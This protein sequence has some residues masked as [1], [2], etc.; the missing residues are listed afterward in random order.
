MRA[1][2]DD[3]GTRLKVAVTGTPGTPLVFLGN[4]EIEDRWAMG[5]PGLPGVSFPAGRA[6]VNRMDEFTLLLAGP[7][8]HVVL[9]A[10]P[11]PGYLSYLG[12]LGLTPPRILAIGR[13]DPQRTVTADILA[14]PAI[15]TALGRLARGGARL[16][17]HG[18][19]DLEEQLAETSEIPLAAPAAAVCKRVNSK[20]YSRRL[21]EELDLRR[22]RGWAAETL[23][24]LDE[25]VGRARLLLAAGHTVVVKDAYGVSGRGI[26][27]VAT[28][29]RLDRLQRM[30]IR[31]AERAGHRRAGLVVEEWVAK[32]TDLNYQFTIGRDG[33]VHFD[34]VKEAITEAGVHKGHRFPAGLTAAQEAGV[35]DSAQRIGAALAADG[36]FGVAGVDALLDPDGGLYP[37]IEI[38]ARNNMS[39]YQARIQETLGTGGNPVLARHYPVRLRAPLAFADLRRALK[40]VLLERDSDSGLLI[41]N[42]ATVNAAA[43]AGDMPAGGYDGRLYGL[44]LARDPHQL[45]AIDTEISIRLAAL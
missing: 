21:A 35:R 1:Q 41:N 4:F 28:V 33:A 42:F 34:F 40:G 22:P 2:P 38:N 26:A 19:S 23:D 29:E 11:D 12:E 16:F 18:V 20:I 17:P 9:K 8:D 30:A 27:V 24:E 25:A 39:T 6:V 5:E 10:A 32:H 44:V 15:R 43:P 7:D 13:Q 31:R 14:D 36:Y 37:M 45:A 3:F